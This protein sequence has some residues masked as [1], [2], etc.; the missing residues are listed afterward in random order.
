LVILSAQLQF[1]HGTFGN[2][3]AL[4]SGVGYALVTLFMRKW[5]DAGTEGGLALGNFLLAAIGIGVACRSAQ[6][7]VWPDLR[8]GS[9]ILWLGVF[10]IGLAYFLFQGALRRITAVEASLLALLEPVLC[11]IWAWLYVADVPP[12]R[13]M[14][15][16][17]II[18]LTLAANTIWK[19]RTER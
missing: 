4:I 10:Q 2:V 12:R 19:A 8:S 14:L 15:G 11:P 9:Q 5:R 1:G 6:G 17:A 13:S 18:L 7:I 3:M 16:G